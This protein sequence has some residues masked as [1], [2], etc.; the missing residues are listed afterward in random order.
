MVQ[1][2]K[3]IQTT[4]SRFFDVT[5]TNGRIY[6]PNKEKLHSP[7][8]SRQ[9]IQKGA[10]FVE[11]GEF[12][13]KGKSPSK[14][15]DELWW[16]ILAEIETEEQFFALCKERCPIDYVT[17]YPQLKTLGI[18][19]NESDPYILAPLIHFLF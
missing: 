6:H 2:M 19:T 13:S 3:K 5:G 10:K 16:G 8:A 9:Y 7:T 15:R 14:N 1:C 11:C 18:I 4:N 12:S 17:K